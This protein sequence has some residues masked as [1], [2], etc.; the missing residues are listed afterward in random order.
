MRGMLAGYRLRV[1][2]MRFQL[3]PFR[4]G[5]RIARLHF[6]H[7]FGPRDIFAGAIFGDAEPGEHRPAEAEHH[8]R[9]RSQG[10]EREEKQRRER[11]DM[12]DV[13]RPEQHEH[14]EQAECQQPQIAAVI[15]IGDRDRPVGRHRL[16]GQ[17]HHAGAEQEFEQA[18]LGAGEEQVHRPPGIAIRRAPPDQ[19]D[20][21]REGPDAG[22]HIRDIDVE[23]AED[24]D[25]A[26][27]VEH[28]DAGPA[29]HRR[30]SAIARFHHAPRPTPE[31]PPV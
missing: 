28:I 15:E 24:R 31:K 17:H 4:H 26:Q 8:Q 14:I 2:R 6:L 22:R 12:E 20:I 5:D 25:P 19:P 7:Q 23:D 18:A 9:L 1:G 11:I 10:P 16:A 3:A 27:H 13:A 21:G 30:Q 29:L